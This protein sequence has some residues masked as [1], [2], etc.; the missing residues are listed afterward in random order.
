[1]K[2]DF[3]SCMTRTKKKKKKEKTFHSLKR[4][5]SSVHP[6]PPGFVSFCNETRQKQFSYTSVCDL[7]NVFLFVSLLFNVSHLLKFVV[8]ISDKL[9]TPQ[10]TFNYLGNKTCIIAVHICTSAVSIKI[11]FFFLMKFLSTFSVRSS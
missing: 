11:R 9:T 5:F 4:C 1:M 2:N 3:H 8:R 7:L 6:N 10:K